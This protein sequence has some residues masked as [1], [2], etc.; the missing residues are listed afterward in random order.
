MAELCPKLVQPVLTRGSDAGTGPRGS[1]TVSHFFA[2]RV[3]QLINK[4][5]ERKTKSGARW[6]VGFELSCVT[7]LLPQGFHDE[8]DQTVGGSIRQKRPI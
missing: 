2:A 7:R 3:G 8:T 5:A 1:W 4:P 6:W